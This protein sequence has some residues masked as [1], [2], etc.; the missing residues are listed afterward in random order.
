M[1]I[2]PDYNSEQ[3][4]SWFDVTSIMKEVENGHYVE[5]CHVIRV[6]RDSD[7]REQLTVTSVALKPGNVKFSG[8]RRQRCTK[9]DRR[10]FK[11]ITAVL[12]NHLLGID[13]DLTAERE[14]AETQAR[15]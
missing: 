10:Q 4:P 13:N 11:T 7:G 15:F 2:K 5:C 1:A 9:W 6:Y 3:G 8:I 14:A 12:Y